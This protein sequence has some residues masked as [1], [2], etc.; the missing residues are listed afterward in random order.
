MLLLVTF[1]SDNFFESFKDG[2]NKDGLKVVI[3]LAVQLFPRH[4]TNCYVY[5]HEV[6]PLKIVRHF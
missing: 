2:N 1:F 3:Y 4:Q 5:R 6:C